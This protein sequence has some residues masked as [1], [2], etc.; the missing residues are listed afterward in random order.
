M[1]NLPMQVCEHFCQKVECWAGV[2]EKRRQVSV[3]HFRDTGKTVV[4]MCHPCSLVI[5]RL[6]KALER[7]GGEEGAG[8]GART[9]DSLLGRQELYH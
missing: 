9:R 6:V 2:C 7:D 1:K 4:S 3:G 8:D 5:K